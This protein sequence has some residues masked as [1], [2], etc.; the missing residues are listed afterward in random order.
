MS[1]FKRE[2]AIF[3]VSWSIFGQYLSRRGVVWCFVG[4][5]VGFE[6]AVAVLPHACIFG[7]NLSTAF[8]SFRLRVA[9][10][11]VGVPVKRVVAVLVLC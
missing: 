9:G 5:L 6:K 1:D 2:V 3:L 10:L 11:A 7:P 8:T 4:I